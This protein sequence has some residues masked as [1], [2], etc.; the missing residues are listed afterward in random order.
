MKIIDK[1]GRE[2]FKGDEV[3]MP[4]PDDAFNDLH[5]HSFQGS[6]IGLEEDGIITV[7]DQDDNVFAIEANRVE[8]E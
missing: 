8:I 6:I 2:L 4:E 7:V 3:N 1:N 5:Q